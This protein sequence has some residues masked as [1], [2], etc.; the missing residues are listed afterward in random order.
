MWKIVYLGL[1]ALDV[2]SSR[3]ESTANIVGDIH[4]VSIKPSEE[5]F[6]KDDDGDGWVKKQVVKEVT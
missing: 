3:S 4:P 2:H 5:R 6:Y 1:A